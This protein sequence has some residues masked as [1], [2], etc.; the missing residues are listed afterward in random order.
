MQYTYPIRPQ[1]KRRRTTSST[2]PLLQMANK[3]G[4]RTGHHDVLTSFTHRAS[5][6]AKHITHRHMVCPPMDG[7]IGSL[8]STN[9]DS[10]PTVLQDHA[11]G[12]ELMEAWPASSWLSK[13]MATAYVTYG[14][15]DPRLA[16]PRTRTS[17][18]LGEPCDTGSRHRQPPPARRVHEFVSLFDKRDTGWA[19]GVRVVK[20]RVEPAILRA[21]C[22]TRWAASSTRSTGTW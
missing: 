7:S 11:R 18:A 13:S 5:F 16:G 19:P 6:E 15:A 12:S 20:H 1:E 21:A 9:P 8:S 17:L 2:R 14:S 3:Q 4:T 22:R 10:V